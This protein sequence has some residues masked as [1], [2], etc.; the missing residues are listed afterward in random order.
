LPYHEWF[1]EFE[2]E[3]EKLERFSSK[4]GFG[5]AQKKHVL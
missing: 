2:K 3:P 5:N 1:I 4:S